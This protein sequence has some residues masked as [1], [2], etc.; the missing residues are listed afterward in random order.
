MKQ[1]SW[2]SAVLPETSTVEQVILNL[3]QTALRAVLICSATGEFIGLVTDGD[4]RRAFIN[5]FNLESSVAM[6]MNSDAIIVPPGA[7]SQEVSTIM[8]VHK[9]EHLPIVDG[10]RRLTGVYTSGARVQQLPLPNRVVIMAGGQGMRLRPLTEDRPKPMIEIGGKPILEHIVTRFRKQGFSEFT[11]SINY[12]GAS[13]KSHFG[14][15]SKLGVSID[16]IEEDK[17]LGTAG[18]LRGLTKTNDLPFIVTNGDV[19]S[20]I[21]YD[22]LIDF[23]LEQKAV[24]TMAIRPFQ[25]QNPFGVIETNG[26][27]IIGIHEKPTY[28]THINTGVY[29]FDPKVIQLLPKSEFCQIPELFDHLRNEGHR[30]IAFHLQDDWIDV[31]NVEDLARAE[32]KF[33][34]S[35]GK[36]S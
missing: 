27:T 18:S 14:D 35:G 28:R 21:A 10:K 7:T 23:H 22:E 29:V 25:I 9:I 33:L 36:Q 15:G 24:A 1:A 12:L 34:D 31:G 5:G 8:E 16:Y 6:I 30:T 19:I 4:I 26:I 20:E 17:P 2:K 13:I 32:K 11:I 3:E